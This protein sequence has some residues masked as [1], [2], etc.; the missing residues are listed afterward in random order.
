M[1]TVSRTSN[2]TMRSSFT[3][4][5]ILALAAGAA[6][7]APSAALDPKVQAY[8]EQHCLKCHDADAEKGD[9]RIDNL[10]PKVGFEDTPQWLE[11]MERISS[12][13]MPPK[14]EKS[15]PTAEHSAPVVEWLAARM[16]EGESARLAEPL[17]PRAFRGKGAEGLK[18]EIPSNRNPFRVN[19]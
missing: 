16:K 15:Q 13:E 17:R 7:A 8:F 9:F 11:I 14:K 2:T 18:K 12:G 6:I 3:L 19:I 5:L 4:T 1:M 10:S